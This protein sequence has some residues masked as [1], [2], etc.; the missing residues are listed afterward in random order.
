VA[1]DLGGDAGDAGPAPELDA[2]S[3]KALKDVRPGREILARREYA[4]ID[5]LAGRRHVAA[6]FRAELVDQFETFLGL[7]MPVGPAIAGS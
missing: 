2:F 7:D 6:D 5:D 1:A 3:C 4:L